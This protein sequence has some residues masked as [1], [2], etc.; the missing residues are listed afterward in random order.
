[1]SSWGE[2]QKRT[3]ISSPLGWVVLGPK[4]SGWSRSN[5]IGESVRN[6]ELQTLSP[7]RLGQ[8]V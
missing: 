1:V 5:S 4:V 3:I 2:S 8:N 6:A 7:R